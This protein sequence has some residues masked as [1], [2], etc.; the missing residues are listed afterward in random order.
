L[1]VGK[2]GKQTKMPI[3]TYLHRHHIAGDTDD[4]DSR[5]P[6]SPFCRSLSTGTLPPSAAATTAAPGGALS[7]GLQAAARFRD[8]KSPLATEFLSADASR[9]TSYL[10][11]VQTAAAYQRYPL[12]TY[13]SGRL[14]A[15]PIRRY[16]DDDAD[17]VINDAKS[18]RIRAVLE[19]I[20]SR[21][22]GR[23]NDGGRRRPETEMASSSSV[24]AELDAFATALDGVETVPIR[25]RD[26]QHVTSGNAD[27]LSSFGDRLALTRGELGRLEQLVSRTFDGQ[28]QQQLR[29]QVGTNKSA[30]AA[31]D[32]FVT[33]DGVFDHYPV[34]E[35]A[36][37]DY[38]KSDTLA[39]L[40]VK[41]AEERRRAVEREIEHH[42][43]REVDYYMPSANITKFANSENFADKEQSSFSDF[44]GRRKL[45]EYL[46][47]QKVL[48]PPVVMTTDRSRPS[49][50]VRQ[51]DV[52]DKGMTS[53]IHHQQQQQH[54]SP[55]RYT[56]S[57][58]AAP[59]VHGTLNSAVGQSGSGVGGNYKSTGAGGNGSRP[60]TSSTTS[61]ETKFSVGASCQA[62]VRM[63]ET[64]RRVREVLCKSKGDPRYFERRRNLY[65][66]ADSD[67]ED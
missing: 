59:A 37:V 29:G 1:V 57:L 65:A 64:R 58:S 23:D 56:R 12:F 19:R 7:A 51:F 4:V 11:G 17:Y 55:T 60:A 16:D 31:A 67:D 36:D 21:D 28:R 13:Q 27:G 32:Q 46:F 10:T 52:Q 54:T 5:L 66:A 9:P 49:E 2:S 39:A 15:K 44:N 33:I 18:R 24:R 63:S 45:D 3:S 22:D 50:S 6:R 25:S 61:I 26:P 47:L 43:H 53:G 20:Q 48:E 62:P 34:A 40:A 30:S 42:R 41:W 38:T 8:L 35:G 14:A